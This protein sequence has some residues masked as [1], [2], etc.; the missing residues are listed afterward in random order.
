MRKKGVRNS[1]ACASITH[2]VHFLLFFTESERQVPV[3]VPTASPCGRTVGDQR[4]FL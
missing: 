2:F 4:N 3:A 1:S